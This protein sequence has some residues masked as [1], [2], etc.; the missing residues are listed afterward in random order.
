[1]G[2]KLSVHD[3]NASFPTVLLLPNCMP[4]LV[5]SPT[6]L[7]CPT[8]IHYHFRTSHILEKMILGERG[9]C[10]VGENTIAVRL[11]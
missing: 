11:T 7:L 10:V 9:I 8:I 6:T 5:V 3:F 2:L 1:M 4:L